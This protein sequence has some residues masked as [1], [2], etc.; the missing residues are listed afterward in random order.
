LVATL[1]P[2]LIFVSSDPICDKNAPQDVGGGEGK[3]NVKKGKNKNRKAKKKSYEDRTKEIFVSNI[4]VS[5]LIQDTI[6]YLLT[7]D[8]FITFGVLKE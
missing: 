1:H 8:L 5:S 7:I 6:T 4:F 2:Y 3:D